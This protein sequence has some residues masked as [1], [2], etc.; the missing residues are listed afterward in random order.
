L[1]GAALGV[2][3]ALVP[4]FIFPQPAGDSGRLLLGVTIL[5]TIVFGFFG[6]ILGGYLHWRFSH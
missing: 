3:L 1:A 2:I 5:A 4:M 6:L